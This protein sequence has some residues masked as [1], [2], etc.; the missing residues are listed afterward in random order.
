MPTAEWDSLAPKISKCTH[1][2]DRVPQ[3]AP[4]AFN[5]QPLSAEA[6]KQF[7]DTIA[8]PACVKACPAD[9]L[10]YG[11]RDEMLAL[12]HKRI[13]DRPDRY[14][15]HI[16]GEKELGGTSVLYLSAVP[17]EKLGFPTYGEKPFTAF[18]STA[19]GAVPP[20]VMAVGGLLG[21]AYAF[22]RKRAQKVADASKH[23]QITATSS[24]RPLR[25]R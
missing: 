6:A 8:I 20:A 25:P 24:S 11:T 16:Y 12:A 13:A 1:C 9:A 10:R 17:F 4:V 7:A 21:A 23:P 22:F 5:G 15:D 3:P 18:T 2:A 14:V 19:L